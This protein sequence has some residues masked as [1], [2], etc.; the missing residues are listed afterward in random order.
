MSDQNPV[1]I[2]GPTNIPDRLRHAMLVQTRDHRAPDFVETLA[3]VLED[4][5]NA[6]PSSMAAA[7]ETLARM[8]ANRRTLAVLGDMLELGGQSAAL[9]R[10]IGRAV[11]DARIDQLLVTGRFASAVAEGA[12]ERKMAAERIFTGTKPALVE[13]LK[14]LLR[15]GDLILVK[16]SRGMAMEEV[17]AAMGRWA[18]DR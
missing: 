9:H 14:R 16:G 12:M 18:E 2:P 15:P 5:Y 11:A 7:I 10:E 13:R 4:T 6:N 3:P 17:V 8:Q 1:F